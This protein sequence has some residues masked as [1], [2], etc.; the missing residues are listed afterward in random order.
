M[1]VLIM[2]KT[3]LHITAG[4]DNWT[5]TT[6]ELAKLTRQFR[7]ALKETSQDDTAVIATRNS[8]VA[9][10]IEFDPSDPQDIWTSGY[11]SSLPTAIS[12]QGNSK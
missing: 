9:T 2:K 12:N 4:D 6:Q 10:V 3:I 7:K 1:S 11:A 8:V 5:P